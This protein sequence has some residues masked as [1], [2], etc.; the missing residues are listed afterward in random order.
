[1]LSV[2]VGDV[3]L[4]PRP[5]ANRIAAGANVTF[6]VKFANQGD[7]A[8]TDVRIRVRIRGAGDTITAQKTV[9]QTL[10]KSE[11]T[12]AIPLGQAPPIGQA[13]TITVEVLPVPGEKNTTNNSQDYSALFTRS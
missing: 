3:A 2:A 7:N 6:N 8:E 12:V 4:Q 1:V 13:V 10:P 5:A 9:D 11:T